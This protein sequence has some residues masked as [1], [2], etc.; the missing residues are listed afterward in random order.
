MQMNKITNIWQSFYWQRHTEF[1][2][3]FSKRICIKLTYER[4]RVDRKVGGRDGR[5]R[6]A[7]ISPNKRRLFTQATQFA[8]NVQEILKSCIIGGQKSWQMHPGRRATDD[9]IREEVCIDARRL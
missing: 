5:R 9:S 8:Y 7:Q 2:Q 3:I 1:R 4:G 6:C